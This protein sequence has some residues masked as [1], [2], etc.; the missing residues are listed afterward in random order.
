MIA[1][2]LSE[3]TGV[4]VCLLEAGPPD[5]NPLIHIPLGIMRVVT[6]PRLDW[7]YRTVPQQNAEGRSIYLPRGRVLGGS[8]S[9]N[10]MVYVRGHPL[11]HDD[12]AK[13]GNVGWSYREVLPSFK[14]SENN[15]RFGEPYHGR[16]GPMNVRNL[17]S[18]NPLTDILIQAARSLQLPENDDFNGYSQD[19]FRR[20]Q[21]TQR[22][23]RRESAATAFLRPARGRHNLAVFSD[24]IVHAI[25]LDGWRARGVTAARSGRSC[26]YSARREVIACVGAFGSPALLLRSGVGDGRALQELDIPVVHHAPEVGENLQDHISASIITSSP[27]TIPYGLSWQSAPWIAGSVPQYALF[28][29]GEPPVH[30]V[31]CADDANGDHQRVPNR[32][33][34]IA[35]RR[36][37]RFSSRGNL[38]GSGRCF[39]R[40]P[41]TASA[42][43][44]A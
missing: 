39:N 35:W 33:C 34:V 12:W 28:K 41:G 10:G 14:R 20:R 37:G 43:A 19:G 15:E 25:T 5:R 11:D 6:H 22:C 32:V 1:N 18:Y 44:V 21:V 2:R 23:G 24:I 9:I 38:Y 30:I 26:T 31:H 8:S 4:M 29:R 27:T 36:A 3:Q 13:G 17:D 16:G 7:G 42:R 40:R